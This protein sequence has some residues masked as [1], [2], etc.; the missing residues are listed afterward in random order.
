MLVLLNDILTNYIL[1]GLIFAF[2]TCFLFILVPD[3]AGL[4]GYR[5]A[6][7][8]MGCGYLAFFTTL[9]FEAMTIQLDMEP[10]LQQIIILS[11][12]ILQAFLFTFALTTLIDVRFFSWSRLIRQLIY[13]I[14][15]S[16]AAF[17]VYFSDSRYSSVILIL[18]ITYYSYKLVGYVFSFRRRYREYKHRMA[19]YFSS[20][21]WERLRWVRRSFYTALSIGILALIYTLCPSMI[22]S[23]LFTLVL[24]GYYAVFGIRFINY[25]FTFHQIEAALNI[26]E[27]ALNTEHQAS[28]ADVPSGNTVQSAELMQRLT[29][30]MTEKRLFTKPDLTIEDI[31]VQAG[32]S[33][34]NV[35]AAINN[36][37]GINF[38]AWVNRFRIEEAKQLIHEGYLQ[39][40]TT[41]A[42]ALATG[43]ANRTSFY[44]VF[45]K[46]TGQSPTDFR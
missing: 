2:G 3:G 37:E 4:R 13:V 44:R 18:L 46:L 21:E 36:C 24:A 42:L 33:Y 40:H 27:P 19:D 9:I 31:S 41:D 1:P 12:S 16:V 15:P 25:A 23:I 11:I 35:S 5:M 34:R 20:D 14:L 8:M 39:Q 28:H 32:D 45:K 26:G 17:V 43:F 38:K 7:R 22:T 30:L 6:R 29:E 10:V